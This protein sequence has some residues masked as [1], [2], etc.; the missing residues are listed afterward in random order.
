MICSE[1]NTMIVVFCLCCR[2]IY[3]S[4][5][6]LQCRTIAITNVTHTKL[7]RTVSLQVVMAVLTL[8]TAAVAMAE[9][10]TEAAMVAVEDT[11]VV[12]VEA[13]VVVVMATGEAM[14]VAMIVMVAGTAVVATV[15]IDTT[16]TAVVVVVVDMDAAK[17]QNNSSHPNRFVMRTGKC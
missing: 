8:V 12:M 14:V 2:Q 16:D 7:Y 10:V 3:L 1:S 9:V 17:L 6:G 5:F 15:V 4:F 13:M 11:V